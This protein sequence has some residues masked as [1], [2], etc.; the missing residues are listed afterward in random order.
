MP[1]NP[2]LVFTIP[3]SGLI[4]NALDGTAA[5]FLTRATV[6][7]IY[8]TADQAGDTMSLTL[9]QGGETQTPIPQGSGI[10]VAQAAGMG[11]IV[12]DDVALNQYGVSAG[13]HL[14]LPIA[15][16]N[17]DVVRLKLFISP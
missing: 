17:G 14:V 6:L 3:A 5:E 7:S 15:G 2:S 4:A 8:A 16:A 1:I 11:P 10:S 9:N 12:P 13:S